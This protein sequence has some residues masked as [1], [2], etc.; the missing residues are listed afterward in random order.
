MMRRIGL[1]LLCLRGDIDE[2]RDVMGMRWG[3]SQKVAMAIVYSKL[4]EIDDQDFVD[5]TFNGIEWV[6]MLE[7]NEVTFGR[8]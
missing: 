3:Y 8:W 2:D 5:E 1:S 7:G 6:N 4:M